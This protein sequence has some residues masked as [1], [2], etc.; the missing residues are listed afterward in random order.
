MRATVLSLALALASLPAARAADDARP[1]LGD[2]VGEYERRA[3]AAMPCVAGE[4]VTLPVAA[5]PP[6]EVR[7]D[8]ASGRLH[9][10]Y[11]MFFNDL[12]E[13]WNW[14]PEEAAAGRDYYLFKFLPL[15]SRVEES[16]ASRNSAVVTRQPSPVSRAGGP[17]GH[18][19]GD[20]VR[21]R[22]DY[23]FAFDNPYDF[24]S[25][26]AGDAM[27]FDAELSLP[28]DEAREI[29]AHGVRLALRGRLAANCLARST[30]FWRANANSPVDETLFKRYLVGR[31][32]DVWFFDAADARILARMRPRPR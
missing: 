26:E 16:A 27:G 8:A 6:V 11:G 24:Y 13:G 18:A 7:Y 3:A 20:A 31:L 1:V 5:D 19:E 14:H 17:S 15:A 28:A 2:P 29:A 32:T 23:F 21:V 25:R 22:T 9:L 10:H 4:A 30:T 12:T